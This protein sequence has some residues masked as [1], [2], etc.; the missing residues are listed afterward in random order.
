MLT[1]GS[2]GG[3]YKAAQAVAGG[4]DGGGGDGVGSGGCGL[5]K[6]WCW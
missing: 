5:R 4:V 3:Q 1:T 2:G 6:W